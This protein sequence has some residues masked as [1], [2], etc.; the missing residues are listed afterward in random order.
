MHVLL[1]GR[2]GADERNEWLRELCRAAPEY[3]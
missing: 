1:S 2:I 3:T